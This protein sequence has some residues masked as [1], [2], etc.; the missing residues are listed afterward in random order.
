MAAQRQAGVATSTSLHKRDALLIH[1]P[2]VGLQQ[3]NKSFLQSDKSLHDVSLSLTLFL[4]H[5][6]YLCGEQQTGGHLKYEAA[7]VTSTA[8]SLK[9]KKK[10][11]DVLALCS[12]PL[13]FN[14]MLKFVC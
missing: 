12:N 4:I 7:H 13:D 14:H 10:K 9:L 8:C 2:R 1:C 3:M 5:V 11:L 6:V